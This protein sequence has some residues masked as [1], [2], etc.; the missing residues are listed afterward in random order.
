MN[1][2]FVH[3]NFPGQFGPALAYL[4]SR[5]VRCWHVNER[6]EGHVNGVDC[7]R[8]RV[9]G[10]ATGRNHLSS[11]SFENAVWHADAI[12]DA[13][14]RA[15][16]PKPDRIVGHSGF[17]STL[18]LREL[19]DAPTINLFEY[20]Y[21]LTGADMDFRPE[22]AP[23]IAEKQRA[24][25]RNAMILLDLDNC[26]AGYSPTHWQ[27][28]LFPKAFR[29]QI[30]VVHDGIDTRL[31]SGDG[32]VAKLNL[33]PSTK[34]VTYVAR[35]FEPQR[36]FDIFVRMATRIAA[37]RND[38][39]FVCVGDPARAGY[40]AYPNGCSPSEYVAGLMN[41]KGVP[42]DRFRFVG[43]VPPTTL[44]A[45]FRRSDL[46]VYLTVPFV[47]S[48]SLLN[49]MSTG[50]VVLA[51]DVDPVTELVEDGVTGLTRNF[52]DI[53]GL[54]KAATHVLADPAKFRPIGR[55]AAEQIKERYSVEVCGP[56]LE[57]LFERAGQEAPTRRTNP[58]T[59]GDQSLTSRP[60]ET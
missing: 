13:V 30:D 39:A 15:Q 7:I 35:S 4:R 23:T 9:Q 50:T 28:S 57:R 55:A 25:T 12:R 34:V 1:I 32:D 22:L 14:E 5:G 11:R 19:F 16:I 58:L 18:Y 60:F 46:H 48:W 44:A 47:P 52:F 6:V 29:D 31:W 20:Y 38:V 59:Q 17:G 21:R 2:L 10:G 8:Y 40:G 36:G 51:S 27:R 24:V 42:R 56:K 54:A 43:A 26:D 37:E 3:K 49:A 45:I 41:A 33:G 53:D